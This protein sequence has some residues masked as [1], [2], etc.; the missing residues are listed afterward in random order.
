[1][2]SVAS[3]Y[4]KLT[5]QFS[6]VVFLGFFLLRVL[7]SKF[8]FFFKCVGLRH[9]VSWL[10]FFNS[11]K[12][13]QC[14]SPVWMESLEWLNAQ[15]LQSGSRPLHLI[16]SDPGSSDSIH[17]LSTFLCNVLI[18]SHNFFKFLSFKCIRSGFFAWHCNYSPENQ[19]NVFN[20]VF[21]FWS[22]SICFSLS[23]IIHSI[24]TPFVRKN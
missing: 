16:N 9:C 5:L 8:F 17:S 6:I 7:K 21:L 22:I 3:F 20:I 14:Y 15:T 4:Y 19:R 24:P 11:G 23:H 10:F 2:I 18:F 13:F 1:M 12:L